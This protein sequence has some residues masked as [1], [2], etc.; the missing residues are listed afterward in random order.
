MAPS[1]NSR[2]SLTPSLA[3]SFAQPLA[4]SFAQPFVQPCARR[5]LAAAAVVL[6]LALAACTQSGE[7]TE[8]NLS[9]QPTTTVDASPEQETEEPSPESTMVTTVYETVEEEPP[10]PSRGECHWQPLEEASPGEE[11]GYYCDG[12]YAVVAWMASGGQALHWWNGTN[13]ERYEPHGH[14]EHAHYPCWDETILRE[15]GAPDGV[16]EHLSLCQ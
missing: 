3:Q 4:Q 9:E 10:A 8:P 13:W 6:P 2:L 15:E 5:A 7:L 11:F 16:F 14:D 1:I 12:Q